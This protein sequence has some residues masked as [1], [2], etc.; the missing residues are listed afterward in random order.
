MSCVP[1]INAY[2]ATHACHLDEAETMKNQQDSC[3]DNPETGKR[4]WLGSIMEKFTFVGHDGVSL[5]SQEEI[6]RTET[7]ATN[8]NGNILSRVRHLSE[9]SNDGR[10]SPVS[11]IDSHN[12]SRHSS[13][14]NPER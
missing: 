3:R 12:R 11:S 14:N 1:S 5:Q 7:T 8:D 6:K 4:S 13:N 2:V 10:S 9:S